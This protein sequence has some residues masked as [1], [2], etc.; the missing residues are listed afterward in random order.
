[1]GIF[2]YESTRI[3]VGLA[4]TFDNYTDME[5]VTEEVGLMPTSTLNKKDA[6]KS[7]FFGRDDAPEDWPYEGEFVCGGWDLYT[8][9]VPTQNLEVASNELLRV[10]KPHI[11]AISSTLKKYDGSARFNVV[12]EINPKMLPS[13]YL[14][15]DFIEVANSLNADIEIDMYML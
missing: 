12:P 9:Y 1:M 14:N 2:M 4:L 13:L 8:E 7:P 3:A 15:K 6:R 5:V 11:D 10:I